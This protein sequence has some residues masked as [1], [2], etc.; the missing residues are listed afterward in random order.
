MKLFKRKPK[1]QPLQLSDALN[2]LVEVDIAT[3]K[4]GKYTYSKKFED[5]V[6]QIRN[7]ELSILTQAKLG[8]EATKNLTTQML[9]LALHNPTRRDVENLITAYVCVKQFSDENRLNLEKE[10]IADLAYATWYLNDHEP[11]VE[12]V[13]EWK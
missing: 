7:D 13:K 4:D 10:V 6:S 1:P 2:K 8:R 5:F 9:A 3:I 11:T 12:E